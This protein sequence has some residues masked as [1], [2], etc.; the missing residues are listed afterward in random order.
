MHGGP[1]CTH[2]CVWCVVCTNINLNSIPQYKKSE[3][4]AFITS[5]FESSEGGC[6]SR[7]NIKLSYTCCDCRHLNQMELNQ[8][9]NFNTG[10]SISVEKSNP[11]TMA[12]LRSTIMKVVLWVGSNV[13]L[14]RRWVTL[15]ETFKLVQ[16]YYD[17]PITSQPH[18]PLHNEKKKNI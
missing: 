15:D 10:I 16:K 5:L 3:K 9:T 4:N 14:M 1:L 8:R 13:P 17:E 11:S 7:I 6:Y 18:S 12:T 2:V